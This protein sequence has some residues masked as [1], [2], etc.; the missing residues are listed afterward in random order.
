MSGWYSPSF[1]SL[2]APQRR[3]CVVYSQTQAIRSFL[4]TDI[5][6]TS[7][8]IAK[9]NVL[10]NQLESKITVRHVP[11]PSNVLIGVLDVP[12]EA[13]RSSKGNGETLESSQKP[14]SDGSF[15]FTMCNPPFF[16]SIDEKVHF[17]KSPAYV[18]PIHML[19][20]ENPH[21]T[22]VA[23]QGELVTSGGEY[24]FVKKMVDDSL[25]LKEY[26]R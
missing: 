2:I 24:E 1:W 9:Q 13:E 8:Q 5:D 26:G 7:I 10:Q 23:T 11:D 16:G 6:P 17:P 4:A 12:D 19:K 3:S 21:A 25:V 20:V 14:Y 15:D 18:A 22:L